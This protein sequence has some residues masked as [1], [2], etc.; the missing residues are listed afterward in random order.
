MSWQRD[1]LV[2]VVASHANKPACGPGLRYQHLRSLVTPAVILSP[3][4]HL[5]FF[6]V[7]NFKAHSQL[8]N[9][10]S[11]FS[12]SRHSNI[13]WIANWSCQRF[14]KEWP[15]STKRKTVS[16]VWQKLCTVSKCLRWELCLTQS[17]DSVWF[18]N[19]YIAAVEHKLFISAGLLN[20]SP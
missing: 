1:I 14:V 10:F 20:S 12:H 17:Q 18:L 13:R 4:F 8:W 3:T 9:A 15:Q 2:A 5:R 7:V 11:K 19:L 16:D 6:L